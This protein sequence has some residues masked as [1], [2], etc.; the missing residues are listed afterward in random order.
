MHQ[1]KTN[2]INMEVEVH[3]EVALAEAPF[4]CI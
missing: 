1:T 3:M 4:S 2:K